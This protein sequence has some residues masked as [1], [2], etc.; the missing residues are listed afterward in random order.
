MTDEEREQRSGLGKT[1]R[2]VAIWAVVIVITA[3]GGFGAG[4]FLR[5][6]EVKDLHQLLGKQKEEI[7]A[8]ITTLEKQVLEAQKS[9]LERAL[10]RAQMKAGL[11]EVLESLTVALAEV[12]QRNFGRAMQKIEA[13]K[14]ALTAASGATASLREAVGAK[15]DE[16]RTGLKN[17][18]VKVRER[19][20]DLAKAL[21][22]GPIPGSKSQ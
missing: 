17:L 4:Y 14:G 13:A 20:S 22:E 21:E 5:D 10:A 2:S 6:R 18:D 1:L 15:L 12:E 19:I 16:I 3:G 11:N 7:A 8:K 9:Q